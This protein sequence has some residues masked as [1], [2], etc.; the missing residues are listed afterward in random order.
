MKKMYVKPEIMIERFD[1]AQHIA[2]CNW[3]LI[4]STKDECSAEPDES[5]T[6]MP[7]LFMSEANGC[8]VTPD[9]FDDL[10]YHDGTSGVTVFAS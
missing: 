6:G 2:D 7:N 3:E 8:F 1:L 5:L 9:A 10:C 4:N